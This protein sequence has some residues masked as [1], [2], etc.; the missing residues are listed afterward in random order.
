MKVVLHA[1]VI[2]VGS[3]PGGATVARELARRGKRVLVLERGQDHRHAP[4]YGTYAGALM[5]TDG[6][7]L[8]FTREGLQVVRPLMVGGATSMYC[9]CAA[10]PP[11]WL[12]TRYGVDVEA[13][14]AETI[15]ELG[16]AVLP[17]ELRGPASTRI[18]E[19][20]RALGFDWQPQLKLMRFGHQGGAWGGSHPPQESLSAKGGA[21]G[22]SH[23]PNESLSATA[24]A[25]SHGC[26]AHCMLGC[27]C[28]AKWSAA[29]FVDDA[30]AAGAELRTGARVERV[31]IEDGHAA[32][33]TG[34]LGGR[35]FTARAA[36]VVLAAGGIGTPRILRASG[37]RAAGQGITMDTTLM[38]YGVTEGAGLGTEP[39]MTWNCHR[40]DDG[41]MLST[42]IDP[43]LLYPIAA[44]LAGPRRL[45][46]WASYGNT[47]GVMIKLRDELSGSVGPHSISKPLAPRDRERLAY[48][49]DIA[50]RT[51][52]AAGCRKDSLFATPLRGTHPGSSARIGA[53]VGPDL[54]TETP[55]LFVCDASTF[56]EALG[57]PTVL[58]L[59]GMG[60]RLGRAL[61][62]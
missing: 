37:F 51:L 4:W 11:E 34:T 5:Y 18:A 17:P 49:R 12:A 20:G 36:V 55:G 59:I 24:V 6:G 21:L 1:E 13:E 48:A 9:G 25:S 44:M 62:V 42:L 15:E 27:R 43:W 3:G 33:V 22:G 54:Q 7:G 8:L 35:P 41:F 38:V 23:P 47:L 39:P 32:G 31:L 29:E 14:V 40:D 26:G 28:G 52:V 50:E 60:K 16:V 58:T 19:A 30:V 53:L 57:R 45:R 56:P 61:V 46:S 10:R 2:V